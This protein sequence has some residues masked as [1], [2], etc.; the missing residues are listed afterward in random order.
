M[1]IKGITDRGQVRDSNQDSFYIDPNGKWCVV[2]DGMGG[3]N[4][5]ETASSMTV[6]TVVKIMENYKGGK[7]EEIMTKALTEANSLVFEKAQSDESLFGM[8]TTAVLCCFSKGKVTVAHVGDSRAY[9]VS[10]GT[11]T[12][13]TKDHSVVQNLIDSGSITEEQ[14]KDHPQKNFITRAIGTDA[15]VEPDFNTVEMKKGDFIVIC[16]DGLSN[17][18]DDPVIC[19]IVTENP[20]GVA[21]QKLAALANINGGKDNITVVVAGM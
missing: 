19:E 7:C 12:R 8:G 5:G 14:A 21:V 1:I 13:I 16:S 3:H 6:E 10:Q 17:M 15:K 9:L 2:A 18:V 4:G 11:I 20:P